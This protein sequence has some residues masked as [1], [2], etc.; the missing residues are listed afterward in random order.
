MNKEEKAAHN[1]AMAIYL[2]EKAISSRN[3]KSINKYIKLS[4]KHYYVYERIID[5]L[6]K[7][8]LTKLN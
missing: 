6:A 2:R 1:L 7:N 4:Q 8:D 3:K 5:K